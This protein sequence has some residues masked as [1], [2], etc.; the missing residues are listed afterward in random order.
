MYI[1]IYISNIDYSNIYIAVLPCHWSSTKSYC[2]FYEY[3]SS[4]ALP[5]LLLTLKPVQRFVWHHKLRILSIEYY[6]QRVVFIFIFSSF[7]IFIHLHDH[8]ITITNTKHIN[9]LSTR[10]FFQC[11]T[12][13]HGPWPSPAVEAVSAYQPSVLWPNNYK[14]M[15]CPKATCYE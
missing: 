11:P 3:P 2:A 4:P 9:L 13:S 12:Q 1:Y 8:Y 6:R 14:G 15:S 5:Y 7:F 10:F